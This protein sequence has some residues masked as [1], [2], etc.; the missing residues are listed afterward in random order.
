MAAHWATQ[1]ADQ[2]ADVADAIIQTL[3]NGRESDGIRHFLSKTSSI[4]R[5]R[6]VK[7]GFQAILRLLPYIQRALFNTKGLS[8]IRWSMNTLTESISRQLL[9]SDQHRR[10]LEISMKAI[11]RKMIELQTKMNELITI[12]DTILENVMH[13][14]QSLSWW[15]GA[16]LSFQINRVTALTDTCDYKLSVAKRQLD[17]LTK[18]VNFK[19]YTAKALLYICVLA[20]MGEYIY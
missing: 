6:D 18:D 4:L 15:E 11:K 1:W 20:G 16:K 9:V 2:L 17:E 10:K 14:G 19:R 3:P 5:N 8:K 13:K 7:S 12:L